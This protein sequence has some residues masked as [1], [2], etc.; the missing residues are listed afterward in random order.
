MRR[1]PIFEDLDPAR[2]SYAT[3]VVDRVL[4]AAVAVGASDI[5][6]DSTPAGIAV[7]W[8][9][10]GSLIGVCEIAD[11]KSTSILGRIKAL[12]RLITYRY[13]VPQEGRLVLADQKLEARV[14][15]LPTLH[16]ERAVIRIV[17]KQTHDW[18]PSQLGLPETTLLRLVSSLQ[19]YSG[20]ILITGTAGSG[21]TTTAYACLRQ[22]LSD[23]ALRRNVV[24]LEDPVEAE[25]AGAAQSQINPSVG[26]DWSAG[27]KALLR[28]DP[29]VMLV[30][31]IRDAETAAVVFQAALTGQ[32]VI[33]TMHARSTADAIR[34]LLDMQVPIQH[35]RSALSGL[36]CQ[37]LVRRLCPSCH[38]SLHSAS[39]VCEACL[40]VGFSGR[41]LLSEMFPNI[42]G[43]LARVL[44]QD[45]DSS[46]IH[47]SA[48][49]LGMQSLAKQ[50]AQEVARGHVNAFEI[51]RHFIDAQYE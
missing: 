34:R 3:H 50:A 6:F 13:D 31:E 48:Q 41:V 7:K 20:V 44:Q 21:K 24:T 22:I 45:A 35:M 42:E 37:R 11:G 46:T 9:V 39:P 19:A 2:D 15:T 1:L 36:I 28:Q 5:H 32:L 14:G 47:A 30:G 17:A 40:G 49:S 26:Y 23:L 10:A 25:L 8:R 29:E 4:Q 51:G 33:S 38:G 12:A 16:G 43:Q 18:L 27:L